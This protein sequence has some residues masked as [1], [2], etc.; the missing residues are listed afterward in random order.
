MCKGKKVVVVYYKSWYWVCP[1]DCVEYAT[2]FI[3]KHDKVKTIKGDFE[4]KLFTAF[5]K[6]K[7]WCEDRNDR[8]YTLID[9]E[10]IQ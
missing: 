2:A 4:I 6:A 10:I 9:E 5:Q 3:C 8:L 1:A 7:K